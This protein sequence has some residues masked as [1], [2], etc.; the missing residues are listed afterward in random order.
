[1]WKW[2]EQ[3]EAEYM[4]GA[5]AMVRDTL[6]LLSIGRPGGK[7]GVRVYCLTVI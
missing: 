5:E 3:S 4:V 1:M 7:E 6:S 2:S